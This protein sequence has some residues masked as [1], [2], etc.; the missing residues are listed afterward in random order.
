MRMDEAE[1][2]E[3]HD[4]KRV[5]DSFR[6][7]GG[8]EVVAGEFGDEAGGGKSV[9][10]VDLGLIVR[11]GL[12]ALAF[13]FDHE[14]FGGIKGGEHRKEVGDVRIGRD[15]EFAGGEIE[16]R[17]VQALFIE[18][19][20]TEVMI[21][22]SVELI[23]GECGAGG[24]NTGQLSADQLA[25]FGGLG[26][27]ADGDFFAGSEQL[28]DVVI[29]GLRRQPGHGMILA[30]RQ[31]ETE[32]ARRDDG[33]VEEH[34]E[35]ISEAEEQQSILREATFDLKIL[36]HHRGEFDGVGHGRDEEWNHET[37]GIHENISQRLARMKRVV[38]LFGVKLFHRDLGGVGRPP[39]VVLH[40]MLG[41]SRNWQ[42][43][44]RDLAD[45]FHVLAPDLRNHGT[46]PHAESMSY[47]EMMADVVAWLDAQGIAKVA[48]LGHS[49]GG[50]TAMLLACRHPERVARLIVADIAPKDYFWVAHRVNFAAM[51]E[52]DLAAVHSRAEAEMRLEARVKSE[53]MRKFL[54][55]NLERAEDGQW[56][57]SI[58]LPA[59]TAALGALEKNSLTTG[60]Q[61]DRFE[62]PAL[63]VA[64]GKSDYI[65][66][67]DEATIR[68]HFPAAR[69][70][71]IGESGHNPHM[72]TRE[73]FVALV[74]PA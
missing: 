35:E 29:E 74:R 7:G 39:L 72:E 18:G 64:G 70:E 3:I 5:H 55:T 43:A 67:E 32:E 33:V 44:G 19:E 28:S 4:P 1:A 62:G 38:R 65:G 11:G 48:L 52:L 31:R 10:R 17:G 49:M 16:P 9:Q 14:Q 73:K 59:I 34:L 37:W 61:G 69:F 46:S 58:N 36:L 66:A 15:A 22:R 13:V 42:T 20:G 68:R 30:F 2:L 41:S 6:T 71:T 53:A 54:V 45:T 24:K 12:P 57:W 27:I 25:G 51:N 23:G 63:F 8:V 26:L 47:P 40:G 56:R 50:K 60:E 21:A